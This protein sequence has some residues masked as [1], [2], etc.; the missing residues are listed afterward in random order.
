M[1]EDAIVS[2]N[3]WGFTPSIL[4]ELEARFTKF[5]ENV[6]ENAAKAEYFLPSVVGELIAEKK[7][8]VKVLTTGEKWYGVTY[9]EDRPIV[10]AAIQKFIEEGTY[11]EKLWS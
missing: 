3:T 10:Q 11:P 2:L 4:A 1:P 7:A 8:R 9:K 6:G 5:L